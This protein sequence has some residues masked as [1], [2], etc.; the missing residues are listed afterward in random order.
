MRKQDEYHI[1]EDLRWNIKRVAESYRNKENSVDPWWEHELREALFELSEQ[2]GWED[3]LIDP[4]EPWEG[5]YHMLVAKALDMRRQALEDQHDMKSLIEDGTYADED[6]VNA[7]IRKNLKDADEV[8]DA[9]TATLD[10]LE[11]MNEG[12]EPK[13]M[14]VVE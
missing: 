14:Y 13:V 12:K 6:Q 10:M 3:D 8:L 4:E 1:S 2:A 5:L 7:L 11:E 9:A